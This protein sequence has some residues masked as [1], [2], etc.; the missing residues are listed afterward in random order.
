MAGIS[1]T[2]LSS[3]GQVVIPESIR[4]QLHLKTGAQFVVVAEKDVVI[5]KNISAPSLDEFDG[6]IAEARKSAE[7]AGLKKTDIKNAIAKVRTKK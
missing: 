5:L 3:K 2:K 1:T 7:K 6:L 4:K